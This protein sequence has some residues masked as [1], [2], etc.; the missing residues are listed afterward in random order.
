MVNEEVVRQ[1]LGHRIVSIRESQGM[2][3]KE[4]ARRLG[5][6]RCCL[7]HWERGV[8]TPS[9]VQVIQLGAALE[10][11]LDELVLGGIAAP[12]GTASL[13]VEQ[14]LRLAQHL[15]LAMEIL[16]AE[17]KRRR[18]ARSSRPPAPQI[19]IEI[20]TPIPARV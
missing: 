19:G 17:Q 14:Y 9:L 5:V 6:R 1:E 8:R 18:A 15:Q 7:S 16:K 10:A 3:Q 11:G 20:P 2:T 12:L 4:L 13:P